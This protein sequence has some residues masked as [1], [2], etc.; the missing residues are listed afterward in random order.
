MS[1]TESVTINPPGART[2][3]TNANLTDAE[4]AAL[5]RAESG[6]DKPVPDGDDKPLLAGKYKSVDELEKGYKE[7]V[8]KLGAPKDEPKPADP[9]DE[10]KG[11]LTIQ[12]TNTDD[13]DAEFAAAEAEFAKDGKLTDDTYAKL[14]KRGIPKRVVDQYISS[15]TGAKANY[16]RQAHDHAGGADKFKA[17][18]AWAATS[19][20]KDMIDAY[21]ALVG[22]GDA[23][24]LKTGINLLKAAYEA[25]TGNEPSLVDG[26]QRATG[27]Q[28]FIDIREMSQFQRDPRYGKDPRYMQEFNARLKASKF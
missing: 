18:S 15:M 26:E 19:G 7:L 14:A 17:M 4:K 6:T 11:D 25:A 3:L 23:G 9:K 5:A 12:P 21:N 24:K 1:G 28:G 10:P 20:D 16:E 2:E 27:A 13:G 8:A 22:S